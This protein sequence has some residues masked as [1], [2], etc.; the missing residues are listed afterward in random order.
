VPTIRDSGGRALNPVSVAGLL[1]GLALLY[2]TSLLV[3]I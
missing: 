1:A 3:S 2:V